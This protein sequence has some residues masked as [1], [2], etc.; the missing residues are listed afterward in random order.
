MGESHADDG[1]SLVEVI[2]AMF[3]LAVIALAL[4]PLM[5]GATRTGV[6][7][8][9]LVAATSFA[10]AQLSPITAD[11]PLVAGTASTCTALQGRKASDVPD[12]AGTGLLASIEVGGCPA[13]YP[14]AVTVTVTVHAADGG[15]LVTLPT[16]IPVVG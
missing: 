10:N 14:G 2:I 3:L 8:R 6:V 9:D 15:T 7:N 13:A 5:I 1:F 16:R 11:F 4:L 12:P